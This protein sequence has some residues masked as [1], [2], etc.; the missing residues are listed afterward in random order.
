MG[1]SF[2]EP[3]AQTGNVE[4][5]GY[6]VNYAVV[7]EGSRTY[8]IKNQIRTKDGQSVLFEVRYV[9]NGQVFGY[10]APNPDNYYLE[11]FSEFDPF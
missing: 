7:K 3:N 5:V 8:Y 1:Y 2:M 10:T 9:E 6:S 11:H 4:K